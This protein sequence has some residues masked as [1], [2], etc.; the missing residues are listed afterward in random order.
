MQKKT[1]CNRA[2]FEAISALVTVDFKFLFECE[3][4]TKNSKDQ[5]IDIYMKE[6]PALVRM[7]SIRLGD[8]ILAEDLVQEVFIKVKQSEFDD[9]IR[10]PLAFLVR[11]ANNI[12]LDYRRSNHRRVLRDHAWQDTHV[13]VRGTTAI[14]DA[15]SAEHVVSSKQRLRQLQRCI[16]D[17]PP[18]CKQVFIAHKL[19]GLSHKEVA[20]RLE[21]SISTVEKHIMRA[22][23]YLA[24]GM[25]NNEDA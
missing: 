5:L 3:P 15:P 19:E 18:K 23:K 12:A 13:S 25:A 10:N 14:H 21:L 17:L 22:I 1:I 2:E 4:V 6:R 7:L 11:V 9:D 8:R 20:N 24:D 16:D